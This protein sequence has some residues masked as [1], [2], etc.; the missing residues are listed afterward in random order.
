MEAVL[1]Y[2][3]A[4]TE[5]DLEFD[6]ASQN[7]EMATRRWMRSMG[8]EPAPGKSAEGHLTEYTEQPLALNAAPSGQLA[9]PL[10]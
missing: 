7:L 9:P 4:S 1:R 3:D 2:A 10:R 8:W 6:R 5:D